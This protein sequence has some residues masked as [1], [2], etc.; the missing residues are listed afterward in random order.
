MCLRMVAFGAFM[1]L[2][3]GNGFAQSSSSTPYDNALCNFAK[4][5]NHLDQGDYVTIRSGPNAKFHI[6]GKLKSGT[7]VYV[8]DGQGS[9]Y[10]IFYNSPKGPCGPPYSTGGLEDQQVK[11]CESGWVE[12][13]TI[14]LISG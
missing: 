1:M 14:D 8:C 3:Q 7:G 12:K 2:L 13:N 10:K 4:V 11:A 6:V 5:A 9:W